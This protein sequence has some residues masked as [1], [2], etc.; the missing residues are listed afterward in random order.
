MRPHVVLENMLEI[1]RIFGS[2]LNTVVRDQSLWDIGKRVLRNAVTF[3]FGANGPTKEHV[4]FGD[5]LMCR[6]L[7][8]PP[9]PYTF[10]SGRGLGVN[11]GCAIAQTNEDDLF[12]MLL[13]IVEC[14]AANHQNALSYTLPAHAAFFA[15]EE[16]KDKPVS[17]VDLL[18]SVS[19]SRKTG[20]ELSFDDKDIRAG[21]AMQFVLGAASMLLSR[22]VTTTIEPAPTRLNAR[23]AEK[24]K[25]PINDVNVVKIVAGAEAA[26]RAAGE[27]F[28]THASPKLH[29]RRGHL[30]T[31]D[32]GGEKER[33][34]PVAPCL[35]GANE[36]A[37][38]VMPKEY[39]VTAGRI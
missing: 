12:W 30:R 11:V 16:Y 23:R 7:F 9:F 33:I 21:K 3:D 15:K 8:R 22:D 4:E 2:N 10:Y 35:V 14:R 20:E 29:W 32:R 31:L 27:T 25:P 5:D 19:K 6:A 17:I 37:R 26:Y 34:V 24:N 38:D 36:S 1:E 18:H 13:V 28:G 39:I